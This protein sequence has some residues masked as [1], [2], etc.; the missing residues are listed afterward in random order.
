[1]P[2]EGGVGGRSCGVWNSGSGGARL[3]ARFDGRLGV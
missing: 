2:S 3:G 1:M